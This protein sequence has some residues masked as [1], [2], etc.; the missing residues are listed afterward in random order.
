M[1]ILF[2]YKRSLA[3]SFEYLKSLTKYWEEFKYQDT[4]LTYRTKNI[5][6]AALNSVKRLINPHFL[7]QSFILD[8]EHK[9][10]LHDQKR[11]IEDLQQEID[12]YNTAFVTRR[13]I[14]YQSLF[15]GTDDNSGTYLNA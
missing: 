10:M 2:A 1:R 9:Q 3:S 7:V 5:F 12:S 11:M 4:Y 14:E 15:D 8:S 6:T 13:L